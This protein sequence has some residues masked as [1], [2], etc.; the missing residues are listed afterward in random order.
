V[1]TVTSPRPG[2]TAGTAGT[3]DVGPG[4]ATISDGQGGQISVGPDGATASDGQGGQVVVG[5]AGSSS[6]PAAVDPGSD[7]G[8]R[9]GVYVADGQ[10]A[11]DGAAQW[12]GTVREAIC[13]VNSGQRNIKGRAGSYA[14]E[15]DTNGPGQ[16][17]LTVKN[18]DD[19]W[20]ATFN[21][22]GDRVVTITPERT[23]VSGAK[24][25]GA[26]GVLQFDAS[27]GC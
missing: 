19:E 27:F 17:G 9:Q 24:L 14:V 16:V 6:E 5:G 25:V 4:G 22:D 15:I 3:V 13:D 12:Q 26:S 7:G 10:V 11:F 20:T 23:I 1:I 18:L 8:S 2:L 21:G